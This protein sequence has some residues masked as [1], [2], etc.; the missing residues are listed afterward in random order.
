MNNLHIVLNN[1]KNDARILRETETISKLNIF[2]KIFVAAILEKESN[3]Y[4]DDLYRS[5]WRVRIR[6]KKLSKRLIP[7]L[8]KYFEWKIRIVNRFSKEGIDIV[9]CHDLN[10]LP[11]GVAL[12]KRKKNTKLIYDAHELET[13]RNGQK[14]IRKVLSKY[15]E[16]S[17]LK[18]VDAM[19]TV[20]PSIQEWYFNEYNRKT[21]LLRN[22]PDRIDFNE[23]DN[24]YDLKNEFGILGKELLFIYQGRIAS[25]RGIKELIE[26]FKKVNKDKHIVFLGDGP[27]VDYVK[28]NATTNIHYKSSVLSTE[29]IYYVASADIGISYINATSLSYKYSLPNKLFE[30]WQALLP[31]IVNNLPDQ[32]Y[33]VEKYNA[34]WVFENPADLEGFIGRI[35]KK[36]IIDKQQGVESA[37]NE[38]N[39]EQESLKLKAL[40]KN[41]SLLCS[42]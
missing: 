8:L 6:T 5:I 39:W 20:S 16:K 42:T 10:A 12:K 29:V 35:T 23:I 11:V 25:G 17:L 18:Y 9:H 14:G 28:S 24:R 21:I 40:Y 37:K 32:K 27:L 3:E 36:D 13:E 4:E 22:T 26:V 34:G 31:V 7:Q 1:F 19:I 41:L 33:L 15:I 30:Q 2:N 38:L